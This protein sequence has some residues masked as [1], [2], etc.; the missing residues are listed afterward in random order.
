MIF[1]NIDEEALV[2]GVTS[3]PSVQLSAGSTR[4]TDV[5][6][7]VDDSIPVSRPAGFVR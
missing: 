6:D 3:K 4:V 1:G 7:E 5:T 2:D